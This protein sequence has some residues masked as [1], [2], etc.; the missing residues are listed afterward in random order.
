[1]IAQGG[2]GLIFE[3]LILAWFKSYLEKIPFRLGYTI[4]DFM[5]SIQEVFLIAQRLFQSYIKGSSLL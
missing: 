5:V 2:L 4:Y 3:L 1:M